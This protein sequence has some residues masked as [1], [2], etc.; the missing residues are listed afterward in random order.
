MPNANMDKIIYTDTG[1]ADMSGNYLTY[2][3]YFWELNEKALKE[4]ADILKDPEHGKFKVRVVRILS[5]CQKPEEVFSIISKEDFMGS[6][7]KLRRYWSKIE[8]TSDFRDWWQT[9]YEEILKRQGKAQ[10]VTG[11][12]SA[13][14]KNLGVK[15]REAR[16]DKEMSQKDLASAVGMKQPDISKIEEGKK[17]ITLET[18]ARI[19]RCLD[20][21]QI[22]IKK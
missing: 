19:C 22:K 15:I 8:K 14:F 4:T 1:K 17:N 18:L 7:P 2:S 11:D 20:I 9:I 10:K 12:P 3:K 16:I 5:R 6:W 13:L 21:E